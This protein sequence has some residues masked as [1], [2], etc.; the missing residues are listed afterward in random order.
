MRIVG[1]LDE[2]KVRQAVGIYSPIY[3]QWIIGTVQDVTEVKITVFALTKNGVFSFD[4][5]GVLSLPASVDGSYFL[6]YCKRLP[7]YIR[8]SDS[9]TI[10]AFIRDHYFELLL[11][12]PDEE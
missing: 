4:K 7:S 1:N 6:A 8:F 12:S 5:N 11:N 2:I 10:L 3:K 9:T